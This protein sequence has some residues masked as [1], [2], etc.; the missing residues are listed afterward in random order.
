MPGDIA[1]ENLIVAYGDHIAVKGISLT[2]KAGVVTAIIGPSG[3]GKTTMLRTLNR[4]N[5]ITEGCTI[6]G[7]VTLDGK[8]IFAMDPVLLRRRVGMVFQKPNPFPMSI[9]ENV[10][11]GVKAINAKKTGYGKLVQTSLERAVLWDEV[12]DR[13]DASAFALSVG[14]QQRLC[15]ARALAVDPEVVLMDEPAAALD[16]L[17]TSKLED[18]IIA[19]RGIRAE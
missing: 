7:A 8:D 16:P 4:L 17:S 2:F 19:M 1:I 15:I 6:Q 5:D 9:K 10:I 12:K 14:Q 11:Y 13:L 3:C 18:G